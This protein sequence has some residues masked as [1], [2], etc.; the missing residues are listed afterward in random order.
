LTCTNDLLEGLGGW[1]NTVA[2]KFA[3]GYLQWEDLYQEAAVAVLRAGV[4]EEA[5]A[6]TVALRAMSKY[7]D[8]QGLTRTSKGRC[9]VGRSQWSDLEQVVTTDEPAGV[10]WDNLSGHMTPD[11]LQVL[12]LWAESGQ[13]TADIGRALG[14]SG[15][16]ASSRLRKALQQVKEK[17]NEQHCG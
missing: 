10:F 17:W 16:A 11:Q 15:S 4:T 8:R 9:V 13:S 14:V 1:L 12:R 3:N 5:L 6:K 7:R 2:R